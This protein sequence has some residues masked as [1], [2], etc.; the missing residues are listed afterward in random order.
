[1]TSPQFLG[2][3]LV[4]QIVPEPSDGQDEILPDSG[5]KTITT[6]ILEGRMS[7]WIGPRLDRTSGSFGQQLGLHGY[8]LAGLE[9][10]GLVRPAASGARSLESKTLRRKTPTPAYGLRDNTETLG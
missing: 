6:V 9:P 8:R 3:Q 2:I 7:S 10:E 4:C 1:M 5:R